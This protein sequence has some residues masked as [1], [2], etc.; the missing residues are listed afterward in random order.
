MAW[1]P[2]AAPDVCTGPPRAAP[3]VCTGAEAPAPGSGPEPRTA[4]RP[5][6]CVSDRH[7]CVEDVFNRERRRPARRA[8]PKP[9]FF[10]LSALT[11][12]GLRGEGRTVSPNLQEL[13]P[14]LGHMGKQGIMILCHEGGST[15]STGDELPQGGWWG[16]QGRLS[17]GGG[18]RGGNLGRTTG[19]ALNPLVSAPFA[20]RPF[21]RIRP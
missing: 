6:G 11:G 16:C 7:G 2:R 19:W 1:A 3:D 20:G 13:T 14:L 10:L 8:A 15:G 9:G 18:S 5:S 21:F 4:R 17:R 12:A